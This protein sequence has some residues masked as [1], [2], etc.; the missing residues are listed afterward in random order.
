MSKKGRR[1][2][3]RNDRIF[4]W[5]VRHDDEDDDRLYLV[6]ASDDK[7]FIVSYMLGQRDQERPFSPATPLIIVKGAEFKGLA[8][9]GHIW[10]RFAVP[11][12]E[13]DVVTPSLVAQIIDWCLTTETVTPVNWKGDILSSRRMNI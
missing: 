4:Y 13:D 7:K 12:W 1:K 8:D 9:L 11:E 6:I 5:C 10:E 2:I 3:V